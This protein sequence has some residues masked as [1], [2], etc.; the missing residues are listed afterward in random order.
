[1]IKKQPSPVI[2][3]YGDSTLRQ[4]DIECFDDGRWLND[5]CLSFYYEYLNNTSNKSDLINS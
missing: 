2:L 5:N 3:T 1:M 4:T